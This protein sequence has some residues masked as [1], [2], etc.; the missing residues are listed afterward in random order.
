MHPEAHNSNTDVARRFA[1][2]Q[3][4][5]ELAERYHAEQVLARSVAARSRPATI[6]TAGRRVFYFRCYAGKRARQAREGRWYGPALVIGQ[7]GRSAYWVQFGGR[8]YLCA[9]QHLR[10]LNPDEEV[11]AQAPIAKA[12]KDLHKICGRPEVPYEDLT[13]QQVDPGV[14]D[15]VAEE[16]ELLNEEDLTMERL[17]PKSELPPEYEAMARNA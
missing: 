16:E 5:Q 2:R 14:L 9:E 7:Q 13:Q 6:F 15:A 12:M 11:L 3:F 1:L 10:V 8:L 17:R 4:G